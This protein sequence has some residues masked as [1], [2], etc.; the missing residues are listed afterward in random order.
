MSHI[1]LMWTN[2]IVQRI[3]IVNSPMLKRDY[4]ENPMLSAIKSFITIVGKKNKN[5]NI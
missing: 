2:H 5:R 1:K 3:N 4:Q